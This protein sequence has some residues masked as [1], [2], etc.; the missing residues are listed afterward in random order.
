MAPAE[1]RDVET[2]T[3][4]PD[5][6]LLAVG[7][8]GGPGGYWAT[9]TLG[10]ALYD[11]LSGTWSRTQPPLVRRDG[12]ATAT[13]LGTGQVL[14]AGGFQVE[15]AKEPPVRDHYTVFATTSAS[16]SCDFIDGAQAF[17][18]F[19]RFEGRSPA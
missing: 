17:P 3:A 9:W 15:P 2:L 5:G 12:G 13:L 1:M 18:R 16:R 19:R 4:L 10:A 14:L 8:F 6:R 11:P 7:H